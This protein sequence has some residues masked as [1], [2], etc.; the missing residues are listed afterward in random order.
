MFFLVFIPRERRSCIAIMTNILN[1]I[2]NKT[3]FW[4][5]DTEVSSSCFSSP[6]PC[7]PALL[8]H[9][10][11]H[12]LFSISVRPA[13]SIQMITVS[14]MFCLQKSLTTGLNMLYCNHISRMWSWECFP[15]FHKDVF[16]QGPGILSMR[17][18]LLRL[19]Q[20]VR[21]SVW[22]SGE[23][24]HLKYQ[25]IVFQ[26]A[27]SLFVQKNPQKPHRNPLSLCLG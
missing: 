24:R 23:R 27:V 5:A 1:Y 11:C 13:C 25:M 22:C 7:L 8:P 10:I 16:N 14:K 2:L 9:S 15:L 3:L 6:L 18:Q 12:S 4:R 20:R 17:I 21:N 26:E 19:S